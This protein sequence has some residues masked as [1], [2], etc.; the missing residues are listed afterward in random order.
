MLSYKELAFINKIVFEFFFIRD[1]V[2]F[3]GA[4]VH[5]LNIASPVVIL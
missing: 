5:G 2:I 1:L 3:S 4:S